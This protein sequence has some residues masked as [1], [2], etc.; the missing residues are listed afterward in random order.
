M[1]GLVLFILD[2]RTIPKRMRMNGPFLD[3]EKPIYELEK[4]INDLK[5][6]SGHQG[7]DSLEGLELTREIAA[8]EQKLD[9][10]A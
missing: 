6:L 5:E 1:C 4:R 8:L 7:D 10:L 9:R 3:F 2:R